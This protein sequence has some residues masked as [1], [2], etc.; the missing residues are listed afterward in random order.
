MPTEL[1]KLQ[2][3]FSHFIDCHVRQGNDLKLSITLAKL[4]WDSI[5]FLDREIIWGFYVF[6][7]LHGI[8]HLAG[9][10]QTGTETGSLL[11]AA[12]AY[13]VKVWKGGMLQ[14]PVGMG[15]G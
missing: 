9:S 4:S 8:D 2:Y 5:S 12:A 6:I 3:F 15:Q 11:Q 13:Q 10:L 14:D 7:C 1:Q